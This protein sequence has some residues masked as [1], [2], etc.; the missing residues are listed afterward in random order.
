MLSPKVE[1]QNTILNAC[2]DFCESTGYRSHPSEPNL[3]HNLQEVLPHN[4]AHLMSFDNNNSTSNCMEEKGNGKK[5]SLQVIVE[6]D[7]TLNSNSVEKDDIKKNRG[8]PSVV[9][10]RDAYE[11]EESEASNNVNK[12]SDDNPICPICLCQFEVGESVVWSKLQAMDGGC[13]HVFHRECFLPWAKSG[14]LRCPVC[15]DTFWSM[16]SRRAIRLSQVPTADRGLDH[17]VQANNDDTLVP[18]REFVSGEETRIEQLQ[19]RMELGVPSLPPQQDTVKL[20]SRATLSRI[21]PIDESSDQVVSSSQMRQK[22]DNVSKY[23]QEVTPWY[24]AIFRKKKPLESIAEKSNF[25][26]V[27]GLVSPCGSN[28]SDDS[29]SKK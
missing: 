10:P 17:N 25:C 24:V 15:R 12:S 21:V 11:C 18:E 29:K 27:C 14:H 2:H 20:F 23:Q 4:K 6:D 16:N 5:K 26:V 7:Q 28:F 3:L 8:N 1:F 9:T 19:N 13:K 22:V